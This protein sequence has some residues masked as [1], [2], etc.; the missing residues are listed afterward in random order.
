[1]SNRQLVDQLSDLRVWAGRSVVLNAAVELTVL[2]QI[3]LVQ[4]TMAACVA[5]VQV[6]GSVPVLVNLQVVSVL[7]AWS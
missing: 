7:C 3:N 2:G 4:V 5:S 6:L 1:M